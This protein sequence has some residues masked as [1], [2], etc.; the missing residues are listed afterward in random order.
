MIFTAPCEKG[1]PGIWHKMSLEG[2][3]LQVPRKGRGERGHPCV[4]Q[5]GLSRD[6]PE[7]MQVGQ[8]PSREGLGRPGLQ[9]PSPPLRCAR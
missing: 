5:Q 4:A 8:D 1:F 2:W 3:D 9:P 6:G 7:Q